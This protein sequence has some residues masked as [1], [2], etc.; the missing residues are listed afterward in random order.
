MG[1]NF[2]NPSLGISLLN[3]KVNILK[4]S[5]LYLCVSLVSSTL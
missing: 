5:K 1:H 4:I 2:K 3:S